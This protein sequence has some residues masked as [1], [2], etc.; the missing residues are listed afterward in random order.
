MIK[1]ATTLSRL[2]DGAMVL[3]SAEGAM[4]ATTLVSAAI[5]IS[6]GVMTLIEKDKADAAYGSYVSEMDRPVTVKQLVESADPE[7]QQSLLLYW[8]LATS[9]YKVGDKVGTGRMTSAELCASNAWTTAQC[10]TAKEMIT[11][12]AKAAGY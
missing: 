8:A 4:I 12:A 2:A 6:K 11:A 10:A 5:E 9:P 1:G 3:K 7:D